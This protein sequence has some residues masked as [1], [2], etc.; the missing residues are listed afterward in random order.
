ILGTVRP[1]CHRS[2]ARVSR[3]LP[4][5][6]SGRWGGD[7]RWE[8]GCKDARR[9]RA[10]Q[11]VLRGHHPQEKE[12]TEGRARHCGH[13]VGARQG[14]GAHARG[15]RCSLGN[16][17]TDLVRLKA[18]EIGIVALLTT[19]KQVVVEASC[20]SGYA[21]CAYIIAIEEAAY[22]CVSGR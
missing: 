12:G 7:E 3:G 18:D 15:V 4:A 8:G 21:P 11:Q 22:A 16:P 14:H 13:G 19:L 10:S 5:R 20:I 17:G 1:S 6:T 9:G 2:A